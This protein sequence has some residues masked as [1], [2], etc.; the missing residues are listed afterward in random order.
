[1]QKFNYHTHTT[2]CGHADFD[3]KDEDYVEE[4]IKMGFKKIAFTDH[5][6]QKNKIDKRD[7]VRMEYDEKKQYLDSIKSLKEKYVDKIEI[8]SGYEVEYI[9]GEEANILEL[10]EETDTLILGQHFV[11]NSNNQL[12]ICGKCDLEKEDLMKYA[13]YIERAVELGIPDIIAHPDIYM[14]MRKTFEETEAEVANRICRVAQKYNIPLEINLAKVYN[15]T[16]YENRKPNNDP[17]E[18][19][20]ERLCNVYYP[21]RE[22]WQI[23]SCYDI[24]V[25][26]GIDAHH[27]GQVS[28]FSNLVMLANEIIGQETLQKLKF[29]QN[30]NEI[31]SHETY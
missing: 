24:K 23:A 15:A 28:L 25:L 26:Y 30:E 1:M 18:K 10:K 31:A 8:K 11:Y 6:P 3:M 14:L 21:C 22:F 2:R 5:C 16:Y 17:I 20:K 9:P 27:R 4:Y 29:V 19:Q 13:S 7:K 12:K